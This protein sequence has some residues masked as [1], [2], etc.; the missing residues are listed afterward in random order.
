MKPKKDIPLDVNPQILLEHCVAQNNNMSGPALILSSTLNVPELDSEICNDEVMQAIA[1]LKSNRAPGIDGLPAEVYKSLN[2]DFISVFTLLFN[3]ILNTGCYPKAWS[4]GIITPIHKGGSKRD[5]NNYHGITLLNSGGKIFTSIIHWRLL[6]WAEERCLI[7][8]SQFGFRSNRST[9]DC[10]F[11]LNVLVEKSLTT[12]KSLHMCYVDF[13]KAFDSVNHTLLWVQL[14]EI[15]VSNK[16]L[17][18]VQ[19]M[20]ANATSCIKLSRNTVTF[21]EVW[22]TI[23]SHVK[24]GSGRGAY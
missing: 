7:P 14:A 22:N 4:T 16:L 12:G 3:H 6:E 13:R 19:S 15:E 24:E 10:T 20:Y 2:S 5:P 23:P 18:V 21:Y 1:R 17:P 11:I 9:I 8:E